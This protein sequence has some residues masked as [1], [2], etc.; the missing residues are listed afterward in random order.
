MFKHIS[1]RNKILLGFGVIF[2]LLSLAGVVSI[3]AVRKI[4]G[5]AEFI[6]DVAFREAEHLIEAESIVRQMASHISSAVDTGTGEEIKKARELREALLQKLAEAEK[7]APGDQVLEDHFRELR[8]KVDRYVAVGERLVNLTI[9]QVWTQIG[10]V[11]RDFA[12]EQKEILEVIAHIKDHGVKQLNGSLLEISALTN[13]TAT[14]IP[15]FMAAALLAGV[16]FAY[17][18]GYQ[19]ANPI[20]KL[21]ERMKRAEGGDFTVRADASRRDELGR[22]AVGFNEMLSRLQGRDAELEL[23]RNHLEQLVAQRTTELEAANTKLNLELTE[24]KRAEQALIDSEE[25]IKNILDSV[26]AGIMIIDAES[27]TLVGVNAFAAELIGAEPKQILGRSCHHFVCP[28]A[29]GKCPITDLHLSVDNAERTLVRADGTTL[30]II[31]SVVPIVYRGRTRLIES[32]VD[33]TVLKQAETA[34]RESE[35][36]HR[37]LFESAQDAI[38]ILEGQGENIGRIVDVNKA[39]ANMHGYTAKELYAM[40]IRDLDSPSSAQYTPNLIARILS[41]EWVQA[42]AT[43]CRKDGAEFPVEISAGLL[44]LPDHKYILAIDRDITERKRAEEALRRTKE[45]IQTTLNSMNDSIAIIDVDSYRIVGANRRFLEEHAMAE[46]EAI[47]KTCYEITHGRRDV[48]RPPDDPC[49]LA[50]TVRTGAHTTTEHVH[51]CGSKTKRFFE[52]S[53]SPIP[54]ERGRISQV[55]HVTRDI[56]ARKRAE[57][58]LRSFAE[59]L[60]KSN[61]DLQDFAYVASHDLQEPLRK[62]QTFG[63]RLKD[64]YSD[65]LGDQGRDYIERMQSAS[66]RMQILINDLLTYS[67]VTTKAQPFAPVDLGAVVREVLSDLEIRIEQTAGRVDVNGLPTIDADALQMRQLFQNLIGNALKFHRK[68]IPPVVTIRSEIVP[69]SRGR[70][71]TGGTTSWDCVITIAD[72]GIGFDQKYADRIFGVFQRLHGRSEYEGTGVG[73]AVCRKIVERHGG[74]IDA[75]GTPE[76]GASFI[77][78][79]PALHDQEEA[80]RSTSDGAA[81][82]VAD[83]SAS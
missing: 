30:P 45:L 76:R 1:I 20:D 16:S 74:R 82:G 6:K 21:L 26:H 52:V 24:R 36:R 25:Y 14:T 13:R 7:L 17:F 60:K 79:L 44:P 5:N 32:F 3:F 55:V 4:D 28:A 72:N 59:K 77:V 83:G 33:I 35:I 57:D 46:D 56:T 67:R 41:G 34:L 49:P 64:K 71:Y 2:I 8:S 42:E 69:S 58:D 62:V 61:R 65:V 29:D 70:L 48:C 23:H 47:G 81:A 40:T 78:T 51:C 73:L 11:T 38:F 18:F 63:D 12:R 66:Q 75:T 43:H 10:P 80:K 19:I 22:L 50:D 68:D 27:H 15:L 31:K 54:D 9:N 37:M 39:A 53:T